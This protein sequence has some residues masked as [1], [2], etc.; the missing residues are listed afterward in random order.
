MAAPLNARHGYS[1][2][3]LQTVLERSVDLAESLGRDDSLLSGLVGLWSSQFVQGHIADAHRTAVRALHLVP[4][5]SDLAGAA[6]FACAGSALGLGM[7]AEALHHFDTAARLATD[8]SLSVGTRPDIHGQAWS[9]HAHWLLGDDDLAGSSCADAV[10]AARSVDHPY[11]LAVALAYAGITHQ[12][13]G[14]REALESGVAELRNL[15]D[16]YGFAYYC[17]W[18]L[19]LQG[20]LQEG[21][22]GTALTE[23]GIDRLRSEGSFARMPYWLSLL[24]DQLDRAGQRQ[25]AR[26]ILDAAA[27][28]AEARSDVWWLPEVQRQRA[29]Y[30][31]HEAD[32]VPRLCAAAD[33][34]SRHGSIALLRRCQHDLAVHGVRRPAQA[35]RL[36]R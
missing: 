34:A 8:T 23:R 15:C 22:A 26:S 14:D 25:R 11:S 1:S 33:L 16:R 30:D 24:A 27:A 20:W 28:S 21:E 3:R 7:P 6:H 9:A 18:G 32:V 10:A 29:T 12:L 19:V 4:A 31:D 5:G 17:E 35:E 2:P 36:A 13:L